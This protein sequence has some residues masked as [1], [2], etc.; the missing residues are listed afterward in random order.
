MG[1]TATYQDVEIFAVDC[2]V[3]FEKCSVDSPVV[4]LT[5]LN[6]HDNAKIK[7]IFHNRLNFELCRKQCVDLNSC[8]KLVYMSTLEYL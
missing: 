3:F 6:I 8:R 1:V 2:P 7:L 4:F 5:L